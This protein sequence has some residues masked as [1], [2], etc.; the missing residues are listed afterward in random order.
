MVLCSR[1]GDIV[2]DELGRPRV[3]ISFVDL[4]RLAVACLGCSFLVIEDT[5]ESIYEG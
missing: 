3:N 5:A 4:R 2:P 1:A